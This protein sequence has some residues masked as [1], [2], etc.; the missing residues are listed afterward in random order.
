MP[1]WSLLV[2]VAALILTIVTAVWKVS[3]VITKNTS[4]VDNLS[5]KMS[6]FSKTNEKEHAEFDKALEEHTEFEKELDEH[7]HQL[8]DH[9]KRITIIEN[10]PK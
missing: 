1:S 6:D 5:D 3:A 9:E 8:Q 4:A 7:D 2:S 10:T